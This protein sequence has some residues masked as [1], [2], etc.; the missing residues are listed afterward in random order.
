MIYYNGQ[1]F[2]VQFRNTC[3]V[4]MDKVNV[5]MHNVFTIQNVC[6]CSESA[7]DGCDM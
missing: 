3:D 2:S 6:K 5:I 7:C 1:M 4:A